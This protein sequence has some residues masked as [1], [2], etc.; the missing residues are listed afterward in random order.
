MSFL[1]RHGCIVLVLAFGPL[2][3]SLF[4]QESRLAPGDRLR[5]H[6]EASACCPATSTGTLISLTVDSLTYRRSGREG[7]LTI[8]RSSILFAERGR[9]TGHATGAGATLGLIAGALIGGVA[10]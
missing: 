1:V 7:P 6:R 3:D 9:S 2:R 8:P 4:A 5:I 10:G